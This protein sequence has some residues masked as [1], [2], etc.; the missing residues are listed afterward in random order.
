VDYNPL[1]GMLVLI[2]SLNL[3]IVPNAAGPESWGHSRTAFAIYQFQTASQVSL[4]VGFLIS[5]ISLPTKTTK[6]GTLWTKVI[7]Q[8]ISSLTR[9]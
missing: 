8:Y 7:S 5:W 2:S 1:K 4:F 6:I 9:V 3:S